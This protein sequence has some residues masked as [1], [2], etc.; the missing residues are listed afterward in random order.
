[1]NEIVIIGSGP[2]GL[3]TAFYLYKKYD[4]IKC[5]IISHNFEIF[6]CTYCLFLEHIENTWIYDYFDKSKLFL[7]ITNINIDF[8][9]SQCL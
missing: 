9:F 4:N 1:M 5:Y 8:W 3:L 2:V 6:H 7:N